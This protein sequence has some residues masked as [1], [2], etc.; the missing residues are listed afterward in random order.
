MS[1]AILSGNQITSAKDLM[2]QFFVSA[3]AL[4]GSNFITFNMH[5]HLH[6]HGI[7]GK[8]PTNKRSIE[9]QL[10]CHFTNSMH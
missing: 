7:L 8:F 4:Y 6:V 9:I 1:S 2:H 3:E 5:L 10:L